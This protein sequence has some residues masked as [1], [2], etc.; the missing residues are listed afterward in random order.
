MVYKVVAPGPYPPRPQPILSY[1]QPSIHFPYISARPYLRDTAMC[2]AT[3]SPS[4]LNIDTA[5]DW[6]GTLSP[7]PGRLS[8]S[9]LSTCVIRFACH[10]AALSRVSMCKIIMSSEHHVIVLLSEESR[11]RIWHVIVMS[12]HCHVMSQLCSLEG[13]TVSYISHVDI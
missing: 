13:L 12:C 9:R 5:Q 1:H 10:R 2:L 6:R 11:Y 4:M 3:T 7:R 8:T